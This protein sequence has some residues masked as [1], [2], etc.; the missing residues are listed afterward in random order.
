MVLIAG[1]ALFFSTTSFYP[2]HIIGIMLIMA[3]PMIT[4]RLRGDTKATSVYALIYVRWWQNLKATW[5]VGAAVSTAFLVSFYL[6]HRDAVEGYEQ[7][8]P[9]YFF[10][11]AGLA[12]MGYVLYLSVPRPN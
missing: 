1:G 8:F 7:V 10:A 5:P 4:A 9:V 12:L 2:Y 3:G 6:L 11:A